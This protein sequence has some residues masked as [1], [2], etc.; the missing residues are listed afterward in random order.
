MNK[1]NQKTLIL[2]Y[3][4]LKQRRFGI[5]MRTIELDLMAE[6][7]CSNGQTLEQLSK[8]QAVMLV[9]LR[10]FGCSFC[11]EALHEISKI[12][13]ETLAEGTQI[14]F[15]HMTDYA[16]AKPYF[17][18]YNFKDAIQISD[19]DCKYYADFGLVKKGG[20]QLLGLSSF[21]RGFQSTV[22]QGHGLWAALG[23]GFQM[24]GVFLIQD[25]EVKSSFIHQEPSD[26]PNYD[27]L[28]KCCII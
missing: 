26:R 27:A 11:R 5:F 23:D 7:Q 28:R 14:V 2:A 12:Y 24:P 13:D 18:K 17:E 1:L 25:S 3:Q 19:L 4:F 21:V 10:H 6:M 8:N 16:T 15:V 20:K 22:L 9:F